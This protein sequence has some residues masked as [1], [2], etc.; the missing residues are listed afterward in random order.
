VLIA[1]VEYCNGMFE[2]LLCHMSSR[3]SNMHAVCVRG[4]EYAFPMPCSAVQR[5]LEL[6]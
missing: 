6:S 5:V 2:G 4:A 3:L 1:V